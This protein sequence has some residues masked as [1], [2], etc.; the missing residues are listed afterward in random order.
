MFSGDVRMT[1]VSRWKMPPI[2]VP[3]PHDHHRVWRPH[4]GPRR[5][6][7]YMGLRWSAHGSAWRA[8]VMSSASD[9]LWHTHPAQTS[10]TDPRPL[11]NV[12]VQNSLRRCAYRCFTVEA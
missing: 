7:M 11:L 2:T 8:T 5:P 6:R 3:R 10:V 12:G 9:P 1:A 4:A